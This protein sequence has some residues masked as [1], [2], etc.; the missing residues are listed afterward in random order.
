[1]LEKTDMAGRESWLLI[2]TCG[3]DCRTTLGLQ[4]RKPRHEAPKQLGFD[5]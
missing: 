2:L 5:L 4:R 1:V 3:D